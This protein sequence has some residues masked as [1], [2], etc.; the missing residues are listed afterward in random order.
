M[1]LLLEQ[2]N[3][4]IKTLYEF[5]EK[6]LEEKKLQS[7]KLIRVNIEKHINILKSKVDKFEKIN[8]SVILAEVLNIETTDEFKEI[9]EEIRKILKNGIILVASVIDNKISLV[10]AVSDNL[11]KDKGFSAGK[12]D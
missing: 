7:K 12:L 4:N 5:R 1:K 3:S 8:G 2:Q 11:I 10:C 9:G 6:F